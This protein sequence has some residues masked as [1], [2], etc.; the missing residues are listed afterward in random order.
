MAFDPAMAPYRGTKIVSRWGY[1]KGLSVSSGLLAELSTHPDS[2]SHGSRGFRWL[3]A[4]SALIVVVGLV[5]LVGGVLVWTRTDLPAG[6]RLVAS[7][8][9]LSLAAFLVPR[10]SRVPKRLRLADDQGVEFRRVANDVA[11]A[12]GTPPADII[13]FDLGVNAAVGRSGWRGKTVL[14]VGIPLWTILTREGRV[15]VLAHEF[16]HLVNGDPMRSLWTY[17]ARSFGARAVEMTGGRNPWSRAVDNADRHMSAGAGALAAVLQFGAAAINTVGATVQLLVDSVAMPDSRRAEFRADLAAR[18]VGG[19]AA[20][21]SSEERLLLAGGILEDLDDLAPRIAPTDLPDRVE[22]S[23]AARRKE[24]LLHRQASRRSGDLWSS[25]PCS[26]D[27]LALMELLP[28][29]G[30]T[31]VIEPERWEAVDAEL[32]EWQRAFHATL[33][34]TRDTFA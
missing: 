3:V 27:R 26:S 20:F 29:V 24:L 9:L 13:I 7:V 23:A 28:S 16:G 6:V 15:S 17:T 21:I 32:K 30:P 14:V 4:L 34:G 22:R 25:H 33:L 8:A 11:A 18:R 19:T 10:P 12:V 2:A 31:L 1:D 5:A